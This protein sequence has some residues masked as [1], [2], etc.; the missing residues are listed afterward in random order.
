ML[1]KKKYKT[2]LCYCD[3]IHCLDPYC[4]IPD[5]INEIETNTFKYINPRY[6]PKL[7]DYWLLINIIQNKRTNT[8]PQQGEKN[9]NTNL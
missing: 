5:E 2:S 3:A 7:L 4:L 1:G 9:E 6:M 8:C